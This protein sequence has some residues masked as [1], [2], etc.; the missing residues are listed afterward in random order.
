VEAPLHILF[1]TSEATPFARTGGLGDVASALPKALAA[2]G[3][4]V[5][6][7]MPFYQSVRNGEFALTQLLSELRVPL[8]TD[9]RTA[10]VWQGE[11]PLADGAAGPQVPVYFIEQDDYFARPGLY[12]NEAGDYPDNAERFIFFCRAVLTLMVRLDWFPHI[13]HCNDWQTGLLAAYIRKLPG[14]GTRFSTTASVYTIH[15]LAYQGLFPGRFFPLTGLPLSLFHPAGVE[16]FGGVSFMKAGLVYA[17]YLTTV[18]PSYAEEICTPEFGNGL[19]GILRMRRQTLV[20]ILNSIDV[21]VWNPA[22]D[23]ALPARYTAMDLRGKAVCKTALLHTYGFPEASDTFLIGMISRL[24]DQKGVDILASALPELLRLPL[25]LLILGSGEPRYEQFLAAQTQA[26]PDRLGVRLE[27]DDDLAHQ[28][29]AGCDAFLMP[30]RYEPCG[31]NQMYSMRYGTVPIVRG[32]GGL[33]DTVLPFDAANREGTGFVFQEATGEALLRAVRQALHIYA[34]A[35]A[36]QRLRQNGM[37]Q[38]FSWGQLVSRY[39]DLYRQALRARQT[40]AG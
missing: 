18:S 27:F 23:P 31:L 3:H 19:E 38:D 15:N 8:L 7:V 29:E 36:W 30:S 25:R 35:T 39:V 11:L 21:E 26:Y 13:L 9:D 37:A 12:G 6:V 34:D 2:L 17:D 24:V 40:T 20:G 1:V 4:E 5:R 33:R 22:T 14:L 10:T 32:I 28:I 16:Y